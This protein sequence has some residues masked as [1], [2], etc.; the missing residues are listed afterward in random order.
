MS[1]VMAAVDEEKFDFTVVCGQP[2]PFL[3]TES[4]TEISV[5]LRKVVQILLFSWIKLLAQFDMKLIA[6]AKQ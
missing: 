6:T 2:P 1:L 5:H 3:Q 4:L